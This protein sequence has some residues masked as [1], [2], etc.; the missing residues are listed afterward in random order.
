MMQLIYV[1]MVIA[2]VC[3]F[4]G[5]LSRFLKFQIGSHDPVI[6][7]RGGMAFLGFSMGLILLQILRRMPQ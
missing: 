5:G 7:W 2:A 6:W 3:F 4:L 1:L